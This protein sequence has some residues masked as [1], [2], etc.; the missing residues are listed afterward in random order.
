MMPVDVSVT[1][2]VLVYYGGV[3]FRGRLGAFG[4]RRGLELTRA[5]LYLP[6]DA[7]ERRG[8]TFGQ[9]VLS[10]GRLFFDLGLRG[11]LTEGEMHHYLA[12]AF[13]VVRDSQPE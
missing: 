4:W 7:L 11:A 2:R 8:D 5:L 3:L 9:G 12:T 1:R 10:L 13:A 6:P